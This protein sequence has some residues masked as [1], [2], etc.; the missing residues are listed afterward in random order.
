MQ[1][2]NE[3]VYDVVVE[4]VEKRFEIFYYNS[5]VINEDVSDRK[6]GVRFFSKVKGENNNIVDCYVTED[7][8]NRLVEGMK[9]KAKIRK[10]IFGSNRVVYSIDE[11]KLIY[12]DTTNEVVKNY[13]NREM[14]KLATFS[15]NNGLRDEKGK[16]G[17]GIAILMS[18]FFLALGIIAYV[19]KFSGNITENTKDLFGPLVLVNIGT[20]ALLLSILYNTYGLKYNVVLKKFYIIFSVLICDVITLISNIYAPEKYYYLNIIISI[21]L[22]AVAVFLF[23]KGL[24]YTRT[25][26]KFRFEVV[27]VFENNGRSRVVLSKLSDEALPTGYPY[28]VY[29]TDDAQKFRQ[30]KYIDLDV[31]NITTLNLNINNPDYWYYDISYIDNKEFIGKNLCG[32]TNFVYINR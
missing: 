13:V 19:I 17:N 28:L 24:R 11:M 10:E 25:R 7:I 3:E 4:V 14:N 27:N 8:Y 2:D 26:T 15:K 16:S 12:D 29:D 1:K 20:F 9:I 32:V 30:F 23:R 5:A 22:V 18:L 6:K 21:I 31:K